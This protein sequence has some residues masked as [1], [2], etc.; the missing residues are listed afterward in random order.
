MEENLEQNDHP[1]P[2]SITVLGDAE[3]NYKWLEEKSKA[4]LLFLD[5][6]EYDLSV[7]VVD[8]E[9]MSMLH[10]KH[11]QVDNATDVLTF[12]HGSNTDTVYA[13]I[14]ICIDVAEAEAATRAHNVHNELLLYNVHGI[15]HCC[16]FDDLDEEGH[17]IMHA[18][19]D[20]VL[21]AIGVGSVWSNAS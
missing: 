5:K 4:A 16:G 12:D 14:A 2:A 7:Q 15:L 21:N 10:I 1:P 13:D 11:S 19:E 18:E 17:A 8:E 6:H 20:R 9:V 3:L